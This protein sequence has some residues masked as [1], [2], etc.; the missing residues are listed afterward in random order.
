VAKACLV[1][2]Y[3]TILRSDYPLRLRAMTVLAGVD[4]EVWVPEW[5]RTAVERDRG[6]LSMAESFAL[7]LR[8]CGKDPHPELVAEL[9]SEDRR[10]LREAS[11]LYDDTAA[12]FAKLRSRG[13][14]IALVSNCQDN[15]RQMLE[16]HGVLPLVDAAVLS[17]EIG[18]IKPSPEIYLTA[19]DDLGV[20][21]ADAVMI[22][23]QLKF[24]MGAEAVG[25][26]AIQV[27]RANHHGEIAETGLPVASS[28]LDTLPLLLRL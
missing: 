22:D 9:V 8:A 27:V 21:A 14:G 2:V 13:T 15:T 10:L 7:T 18:S 1:D 25:I 19:L 12:F 6:K 5:N 24:C 17:Y 23:D 20:V 28:L 11:K 26:R 16:Y 3:D 4:A